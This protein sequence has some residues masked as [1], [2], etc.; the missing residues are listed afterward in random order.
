M[1]LQSHDGSIHLLPALPPAWAAGSFAGLRAR[2]GVTVDAVWIGGKPVSATLRPK[3][4]GPHRLRF[5]AG[6]AVTSIRSGD[7][8]VAFRAAADAV[9]LRLE[10]GRVYDISF[11]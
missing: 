9:E 2:G 1:L 3:V 11:K 5:P 6:T 8:V 4:A 7:M 10:L